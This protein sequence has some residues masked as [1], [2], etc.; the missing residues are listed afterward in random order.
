MSKTFKTAKG[1][2]LPLLDLK[3]KPYL[4]VAHRIVWFREEHP[5][6]RIESTIFEWD[7][8]RK[9]CVAEATIKDQ[10]GKVYANAFKSETSAGF[11]DYI[12]KATT[13]AIGRALALC[14]YGT[15]FT[16]DEL[17]EGERLADAP[18]PQ[19][20]PAPRAIP[21]FDPA[22]YPQPPFPEA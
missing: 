2:E 8:E 7:K 15:Q 10:D 3:G 1:T 12:E 17:D 20:K 14:G 5:D 22:N 9:W 21:R 18:V 16:S 13:G 6:W 4:Q 11:G 19:S